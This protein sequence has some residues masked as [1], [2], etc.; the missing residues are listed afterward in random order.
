[1]EVRGGLRCGLVDGEGASFC[2]GVWTI[3]GGFWAFWICFL[4]IVVKCG[5][6]VISGI[7]VGDG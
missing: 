2:A 3:S 7:N 5:R 4:Y 1:M 6:K